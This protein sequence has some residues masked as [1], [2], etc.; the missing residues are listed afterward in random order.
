[1]KTRPAPHPFVADPELPADLN[2]VQVCARCH[3]LGRPDDAHHA[4][5]DVP[6]DDAQRRAAGEK[7][8]A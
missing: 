6:H 7:E 1:M 3:L 4:M 5:P 2:G 8:D